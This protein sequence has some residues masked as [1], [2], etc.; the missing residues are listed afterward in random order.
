MKPKKSIEDIDVGGKRVLVRCDFNVPIDAGGVITDDNRIV[1]A[2]PTIKYLMG[3]GAKVIL[4]SHL[5][6][7]KGEFNPKFSLAPVAVRLSELLGSP[8]AMAGDVIG[9]SARSL[10][11]AL[12]EGG[13][14]LLENVR[15]HKEEEENDPAFA[16]ELA[17]FADVFVSDAFGTAHRAHASTVGVSAFL[18]AVCGFLIQKEITVIGEALD[19]PVRPFMAILGGAKVSDKIGVISNLLEKVDVII[20]GGGMSYTFFKAL[21][22]GIG[23]SICEND[24]VDLAADLMKKAE[25]KGVRLLLPQDHVVADRRDPAPTSKPSGKGESRRATAEWTSVPGASSSLPGRSAGAAPLSGTAPWAFSRWHPL[26]TEPSAWPGPSRRAVA[27]PSSGAAIPSRRWSLSAS[28]IKS[29]TYPPAAAPPSSSS[30]GS[31]CPASP[32]FSTNRPALETTS[33][34]RQDMDKTWRKPVIAGNWKMNGT[35]DR[36]AALVDAI[37]PLVASAACEVV[38]CPP[39][40]CL[41]AALSAARG[42]NIRVGA[43]NM[44]WEKSAPSQGRFPPKC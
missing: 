42:S 31:I 29:P 15:F 12:K 22:Y 24:K 33:K 39:F 5:G 11:G 23:T 28:P 27:P 18:P 37:K 35:P 20:I 13:A 14:M 8:V 43:Q 1:G 30:R 7:P 16:K 19:H 4:C 3:H 40:V 34:R 17:S 6:R 2:L 36:A 41:P 9:P 10:A 21:G 25:K 38:V 26:R 44:H 32:A